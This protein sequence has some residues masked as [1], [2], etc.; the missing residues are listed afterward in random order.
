MLKYR[1]Y[2]QE[3]Y[4]KS[5]IWGRYHQS[6]TVYNNQIDLTLP[7]AWKPPTKMTYNVFSQLLSVL[8]V[9]MHHSERSSILS[10]THSL[11]GRKGGEKER[12]E[13]WNRT[14]S[15]LTKSPVHTV[16]WARSESVKHNRRQTEGPHHQSHTSK[17]EKQDFY[18]VQYLT[19]K[20]Q[21]C[22]LKFCVIK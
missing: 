4:C 19:F 5:K 9:K 2:F 12:R 22:P 14:R 6:Y 11:W 7:A 15:P 18:K 8:G 10:C 17:K 3:F 13:V 1:R 16:Y 20:C 21:V